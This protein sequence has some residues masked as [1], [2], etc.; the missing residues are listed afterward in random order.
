MSSNANASVPWSQ[1]STASA[2]RRPAAGGGRLRL[3]GGDRPQQAVPGLGRQSAFDAE[4]DAPI[5]VDG[6]RHDREDPLVGA[7]RP[8]DVAGEEALADGD[9]QVLGHGALGRQGLVLVVVPAVAPGPALRRRHP[10]DRFGE[11]GKVPVDRRGGGWRSLIALDRIEQG[12]EGL[13]LGRAQP[14]SSPFQQGAQALG[15][16]FVEAPGE[17]RLEGADGGWARAHPA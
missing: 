11:G 12:Q 14:R 9:E 2:I 3:G 17:R 1:R 13:P 6:R 16:E 10:G 5:V 7:G 15:P 4:L 8:G